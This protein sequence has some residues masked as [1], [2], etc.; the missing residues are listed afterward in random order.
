MR[1]SQRRLADWDKFE[2]FCEFHSRLFP[3]SSNVRQES[4]R[5]Q[6]II[7]SAA[8]YSIPQSSPKSAKPAAR[9]WNSEL[10]A[11]RQQKQFAWHEFKRTRSKANLMQYKKSN[12]IFRRKAKAAKVLCFQKFTSEINS[13]SN[14]K[15][16][17]ADIRRLSGLTSFSP[18][19]LLN[20][21]RG[22][23]LY[24]QDIALEFALHFS[25]VF[26]DSIFSPEFSSSKLTV[27]SSPYLPPSNLSSSARF[28]DSDISI[29]ELLFALS[30]VK[31]KT[32]L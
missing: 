27:L 31:G 11:F 3:F 4:S 25:N 19:S 17:W 2:H 23:L 22:N 14:P 24:P 29:L 15:K 13:S 16:I 32:P 5:F 21:P 12:A 6:K 18:I 7:R 9:W 30:V 20:S 8:N 10:C 26:S 1:N 28:L